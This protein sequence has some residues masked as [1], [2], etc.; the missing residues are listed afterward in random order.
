MECIAGIRHP[1]TGVLSIGERRIDF[2]AGDSADPLAM[3]RL[4]LGHVPE[5][6]QRMGLVTAFEAWESSILGHHLRPKYNAGLLV[7]RPA[8]IDHC[9]GLMGT[10]DVRPTDPMLKSANFSGGN[11][12]KIVMAREVE[13]APEVLIVGQP[14]RGV[15]IGAIEFIHKQLIAMRDKGAAILLVSVELDEIMALSDRIL[16][17]C[18]GRILGTLDAADADERTLGLMMA[19][20]TAEEIS[21]AAA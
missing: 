18:Q 20:A 11:Q 19:G 1:T 6:R 3:R 16:V 12:Q 7:D 4:G 2:S 10:Y 9:S 15:D 8:V 21:G 13:S 14:T 5:D 17:M